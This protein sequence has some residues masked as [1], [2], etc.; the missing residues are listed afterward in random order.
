MG[1]IAKLTKL[2]SQHIYFNKC[3]PLSIVNIVEG[4]SHTCF[5]VIQGTE[6]F[7]VKYIKGR[8]ASNEILSLQQ[9]ST[10]ALSPKLYYSDDSWL[11]TEFRAGVALS[12]A[13]LVQENAIDKAISAMV[14]CHDQKV[15]HKPIDFLALI[16]TFSEHDYFSENIKTALLPVFN[17]L[18]ADIKADN[19]VLCHGDLN[20]TNILIS[21]DQL[22]LIDFECS[23]LAEREFDLSMMVAINQ[24]PITQL[25][26]YVSLYHN[27]SHSAVNL[28]SEKVMRY[29]LLSYVIN[30]LWYFD[31]YKR[32]VQT[33]YLDKA[34]EHK[35]LIYALLESKETI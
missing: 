32:F 34:K 28:D 10:F 31:A 4:E 2:L 1:D 7:F 6:Q 5:K 3:Q 17:T 22:S 23:G 11:I 21:Q 15:A 30:A 33:H 16:N 13:H 20:F 12:D 24:L 14:C 25:N 8:D 29:L 35:N 18:Y 9:L 26:N 19:F 27:K